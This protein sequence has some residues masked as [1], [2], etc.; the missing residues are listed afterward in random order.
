[1]HDEARSGPAAAPIPL[2]P[3]GRAPRAS[4]PWVLM[5]HSVADTD[6]DPYRVTV[7]P[8]RLE[9]Q[10]RWL[11]DR[12]LAG[13]IVFLLPTSES[14]GQPAPHDHASHERGAAAWKPAEDMTPVG[15]E[16]STSCPSAVSWYMYRACDLASGKMVLPGG[17]P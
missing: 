4:T 16:K 17:Q 7:P 1:M 15:S 3:R 2:V 10:L 8:S 5:Y 14:A 9:R 12:G 6:D 11:R 13:H